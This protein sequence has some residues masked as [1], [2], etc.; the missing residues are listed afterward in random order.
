MTDRMIFVFK[1]EYF[2]LPVID[3]T[4]NDIALILSAY[5]NASMSIETRD[6]S[7]LNSKD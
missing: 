4:L 6:I 1:I 3:L 2:Y 5:M 7:D